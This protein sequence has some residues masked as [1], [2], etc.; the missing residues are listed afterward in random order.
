MKTKLHQM[1][2]FDYSAF[3]MSSTSTS[4]LNSNLVNVNKTRNV[5]VSDAQQSTGLI[6]MIGSSKV[7]PFDGSTESNDYQSSNTNNGKRIINLIMIQFWYLKLER[8]QHNYLKVTIAAIEANRTMNARKTTR[9]ALAAVDTIQ[10]VCI[11]KEVVV[12]LI[13]SA[14][15]YSFFLNFI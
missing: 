11:R 15:L 3:N 14:K 13:L 5:Y 9:M 7:S 1:N 2:N 8:R 6:D 12:S 10:L 4:M